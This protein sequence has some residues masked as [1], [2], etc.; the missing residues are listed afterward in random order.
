MENSEKP[1]F[2]AFQENLQQLNPQVRE[3]AVEIAQKLIKE[4][5]YK[6]KAAVEEA[7]SRA[8]EWFYDLEG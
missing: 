5:N 2:D 4:E 3:K 8:E 6:E 7:I 1:S